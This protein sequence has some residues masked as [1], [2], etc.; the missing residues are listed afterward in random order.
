MRPREHTADKGQLIL[1]VLVTFLDFHNLFYD[2]TFVFHRM[3]S[4]TIPTDLYIRLA[5][6][7]TN[8]Q[9]LPASVP[10]GTSMDHSS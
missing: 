4:L 6:K 2:C 8:F 7:T 1:I 5:C 9:N 3:F 10:L